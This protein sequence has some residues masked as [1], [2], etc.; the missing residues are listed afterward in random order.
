MRA[1]SAPRALERPLGPPNRP[2]A[3]ATKLHFLG[4]RNR[5]SRS[6]PSQARSNRFK[7]LQ[8]IDRDG[9]AAPLQRHAIAPSKAQQHSM[10]MFKVVTESPCFVITSKETA[11]CWPAKWTAS[12]RRGNC[13][14]DGSSELPSSKADRAVLRHGI[15]NRIRFSID[16]P[17]CRWSLL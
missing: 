11:A 2:I 17:G 14:G 6:R 1:R 7:N 13:L 3:C 5:V 4:A 15:R 9:F 8:P 16:L 12:L 10:S